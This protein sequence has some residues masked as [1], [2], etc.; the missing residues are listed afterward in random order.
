M[1]TVLGHER[2]MIPDTSVGTD[3]IYYLLYRSGGAE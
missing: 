3:G 1:L 2:D